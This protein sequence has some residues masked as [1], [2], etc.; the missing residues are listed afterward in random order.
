LQAY[1]SLVVVN[2]STKKD[3]RNFHPSPNIIILFCDDLGYGDL[4]ITGHPSIRTPNLDRMAMEGMRLSNFYSG[5]PACTASR[6][7]LLTGKYPARS[8]FDWVLYPKSPRGIH[9]KEITL[10][11]SL[12]QAGYATAC[13]GKWHLDLRKK[14][15][16]PFKTALTNTWAFLTA[17]IC[18]R[19]NGRIFRF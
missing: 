5:S 10:A 3:E 7:A 2:L 1:V 8:G 15:T 4:G 13:Y 14:N 16:C 9:P 17:M 19:L 11:E 12:K 18:S 6:Y